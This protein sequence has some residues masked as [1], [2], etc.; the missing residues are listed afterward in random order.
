V[1]MV[2]EIRDLETAQM[3]IEASLTGHLV[4]STVHTNDA[5]SA[6]TRLNDL[7]IERFLFA[8]PIIGVQAQRLVRKLCVH[9]SMPADAPPAGELFERLEQLNLTGSP[10][11]WR[12]VAG[13]EQCNQTGFR[14][15]MG[16]YELV[17]VD[18]QLQQMILE[19]APV[20]E[21]RRLLKSHGC[22][23]LRDDGLLKARQ[24]LTTV[25]EVLRVTSWQG[26]ISV[27]DNGSA[28]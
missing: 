9:C 24:G 8:N 27:P 10:P 25:E 15:R 4:L 28:I 20:T 3:A 18:E 1:V 11:Q 16:I 21:M 19:G 23:F 14:G 5:V 13:C 26:S 7:G 22:L 17:Q 6:F 2:G 12:K